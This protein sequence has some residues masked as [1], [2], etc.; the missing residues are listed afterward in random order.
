[1]SAQMVMTAAE[2]RRPMMAGE[3]TVF[4]R[5]LRRR[6]SKESRAFFKR[7]FFSIISCRK[8]MT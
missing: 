3:M 5:R 1:M 2:G 6:W 8:M 4:S 7:P